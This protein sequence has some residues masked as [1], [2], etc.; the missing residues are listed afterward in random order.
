MNDIFSLEK[1]TMFTVDGVSQRASL[2]NMQCLAVDL[3][4]FTLYLDVE[5]QEMSVDCPMS[6]K[7]CPYFDQ[8]VDLESATNRN[9]YNNV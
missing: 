7:H 3:T 4:Y 8:N 5:I 2:H 1:K 9:M 6:L